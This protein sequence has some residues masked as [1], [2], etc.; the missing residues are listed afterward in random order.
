MKN[1]F[2]F[3]EIVKVVSPEIIYSEIYGLEGVIMG[4]SQNDDGSWGY[5]V[6]VNEIAWDVNEE[7]LVK[8]GKY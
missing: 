5:A 1:K 2:D 7:Y 4:M 8:T 3:Y 6:S